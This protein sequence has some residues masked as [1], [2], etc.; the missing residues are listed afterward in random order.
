[1]SRSH[2]APPAGYRHEQAGL[3]RNEIGLLLGREHQVSITL[4]LRCERGEDP[5]SHA[6]VGSPHVRALLRAFETQGNSA[7][8]AGIHSRRL[9]FLREYRRL[10]VL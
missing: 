8:I 7:K 4:F 10:I 2:T 1:M 9:L 6:E 3:L 5:A